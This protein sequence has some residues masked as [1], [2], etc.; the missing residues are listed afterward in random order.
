LRARLHWT[1]QKPRRQA[2]ERDE[3][4]I[5]RWKSQ[6]FP[7][8]AAAAHA[9]GAHLVFLDESGYMLTPTVRRTWAPRGG[10]PVLDCSARRDRISAISALTVSPQRRRL[11]LLF[12]LLPDNTNAKAEHVVAFLEELRQRL[13]HGF[14]VLWDGSNIHRKARLVDAYLRKHPEILAE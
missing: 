14:T 2:R 13:P 9:R 11:H 8:I 3:P 12:D 6:C 10:K 4:A 7:R 1:P 5:E